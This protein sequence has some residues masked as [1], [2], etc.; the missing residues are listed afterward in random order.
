MNLDKLS[1]LDKD[2]LIRFFLHYMPM[3]QRGKL[4]RE[5]PAIY[6]RLHDREIVKTTW[7]HERGE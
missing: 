7:P 3:E 6:N 2:T 5:Y 4:G 1:T